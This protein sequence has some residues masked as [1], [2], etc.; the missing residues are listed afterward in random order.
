M[1]GCLLHGR[2]RFANE[3]K[4]RPPRQ[5]KPDEKKEPA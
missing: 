5:E 1:R 2:F 3:D 4:N